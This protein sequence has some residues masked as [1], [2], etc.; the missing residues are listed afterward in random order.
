MSKRASR[1]VKTEQKP[2]VVRTDAG[3]ATNAASNPLFYRTIVPLDRER[4]RLARLDR[5]RRPFGFAERT[6]FI[7]AVAEE[8]TAACRDLA[9]LFLPGTGRP[10]AVFVVGL[11]AGQNL[12]VTAEGEWAAAYVPAFLRRYPF[13]RGDVE[14]GEPIVCIDQSYEGLN[15]ERGEP[16]FEEAGHT[17]FLEQQVGLVNAYFDASQRS[18]EFC[19]LLL[20]LDLFKSVTIDVKSSGSSTAVHGLLAVDEEKL[21]ML[22]ARDFERL[23]KAGALAPIYAHLISMGS[24]GRLS[25]RLDAIRNGVDG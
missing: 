21:N 22:P 18:E 11:S 17:P 4:H 19:D 7:P 24:I 12:L 10:N 25:A 6:Q 5:P 15:Q 1:Q 20:S 2:P 3:Q 13:I 8:F 23:R 16:F 9:I 14:G